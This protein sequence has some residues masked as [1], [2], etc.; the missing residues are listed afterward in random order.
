MNAI[1]L[2]RRLHRHRAW[3][4]RNL[5]DA[6]SGLAEEQLSATFPV[7]QGSIWQSMLHLYAAEYRWLEPLLGN[8]D[9][10]VP[11]DLPG[12]MVGNPPNHVVFEAGWR[13]EAV[14]GLTRGM[15]ES[16]NFAP[17]PVVADAL[18]DAG[19]AEGG[20]LGHCR[21]ANLNVHGCF[22][23]DAVLGRGVNSG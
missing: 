2:V 9:P 10:V 1:E 3:V 22:V 11:G 15:Y 23:L 20:I 7:G 13:T 12:K 18:E 4:N 5:L 14:V 19:C 17:L 21:W 8:D 6:A 16:R